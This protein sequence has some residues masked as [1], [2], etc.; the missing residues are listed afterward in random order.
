MFVIGESI[1]YMEWFIIT[2][3]TKIAEKAIDLGETGKE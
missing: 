1:H 2:I 3:I